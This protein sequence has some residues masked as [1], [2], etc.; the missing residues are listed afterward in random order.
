MPLHRFLFI[1]PTK[2]PTIRDKNKMKCA[3]FAK[4]SK[5]QKV[6]HN[7]IINVRIDWESKKKKKSKGRSRWCGVV[8]CGEVTVAF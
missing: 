4:P 8:V 3:I 5:N 7:N 1:Q 2:T 6:N